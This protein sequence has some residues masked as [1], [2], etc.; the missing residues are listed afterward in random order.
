MRCLLFCSLVTASLWPSSGYSATRGEARRDNAQQNVVARLIA[1]LGADDYAV[2]RR[3]EEQLLKLGLQAFDAL[4]AAEDHEDLEIAERVQ[5]I[6]QQMA[7]DWV[8][9]DDAGDV[10]RLLSRYGDLSEA[11][12]G[13]RVRELAELADHA[14]L[15]ALC[16]IA[17]FDQS[18]AVAR[19]AA[20]AV[21]E[22]K[23]SA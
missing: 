5:Y 19:R 17:R 10:R 16:R 2:R 23:L 8:Q 9:A 4:Q 22:M 15:A 14:G 11:N 12:R 6:V 1:E 3:A 18:P 21:L 20:T 13:D 7:I